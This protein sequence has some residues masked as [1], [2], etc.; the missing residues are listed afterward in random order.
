MLILLWDC[1][2]LFNH[3]FVSTFIVTPL[4]ATPVKFCGEAACFRLFELLLLSSC[5]CCSAALL[6]H[7]SSTQ[8]NVLLLLLLRLLLLLLLLQ[9]QCCPACPACYWGAAH[10]CCCCYV[11]LQIFLPNIFPQSATAPVWPHSFLL[12]NTFWGRWFKFRKN[13]VGNVKSHKSGV[14]LIA[15]AAG[16]CRYFSHLTDF[17]SRQ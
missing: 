1:K 10:C 15:I 7:C 5:C 4:F 13:Q 14:K 2:S 3:C 6:L 16:N 11:I 17:F 8:K 12:S 9:L